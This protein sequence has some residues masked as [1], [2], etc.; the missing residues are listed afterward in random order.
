[1]RVTITMVIRCSVLLR[2]YFP[3]TIIRNP[4]Y[5]NNDNIKKASNVHN[6]LLL[7][8][9]II[10]RISYVSYI[11]FVNYYLF[12]VCLHHKTQSTFPM[13]TYIHKTIFKKK[14]YIKCIQGL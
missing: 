14:L 5:S 7:I 9:Y 8:M 11:Y 10:L 1:M 12:G 13:I 3:G 2:R 6:T 4:V